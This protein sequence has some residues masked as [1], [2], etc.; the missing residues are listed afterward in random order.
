[1]SDSERLSRDD[2]Q[3][4][5]SRDQQWSTA[6]DSL[7]DQNRVLQWQVQSEKTERMKQEAELIMLRRALGPNSTHILRNRLRTTTVKVCFF[8]YFDEGSVF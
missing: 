5:Y 2:V 3:K 1:M 8:S 7:D 4:L 6:F